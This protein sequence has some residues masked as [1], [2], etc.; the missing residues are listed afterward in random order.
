MELARSVAHPFS[1]AYALY[2]AALLREWRQEKEATREASTEA[3]AYASAQGFPFWVAG[4]SML[5]TWSLAEQKEWNETIA[6]FRG[7][8][9]A[10][11][12]M[13]TAL[14]EPHW[15]ALIASAYGE[16]GEAEEGSAT[17]DEALA[18]VARNGE[19]FYQPELH[20][21]Q[22]ELVLSRP[23]GDQ[24]E[25]EARFQEAL[26]LAHRQGAK[27]LE[28]RAAISLSRLWADQG[29]GEEALQV[30]APVYDSFTEGSEVPDLEAA[31][32]LIDDLR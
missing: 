4:G 10:L 17:L 26:A 2:C 19:V 16:A 3:I 25:A 13:G 1:L 22:G 12:A 24:G 14:L 5:Y 32:A 23:T 6:E 21:L 29:R 30:L 11:R 27:S 18:M 7:G 31:R 20:R 8:V 28:L 15:L 9:S